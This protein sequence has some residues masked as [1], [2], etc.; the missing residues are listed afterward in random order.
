LVETQEADPSAGKLSV[1][2][3]V[4]KAVLERTVGDEVEVETP[5]G[6]VQYVVTKVLGSSRRRR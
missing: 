4:G 6:A 3:P 2:S 1:A 5:G